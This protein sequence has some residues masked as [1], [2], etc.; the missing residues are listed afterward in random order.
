MCVIWDV[1]RLTTLCTRNATIYGNVTPAYHSQMYCSFLV[2][3]YERGGGRYQPYD[4]YERPPPRRPYDYPPPQHYND[5]YRYDRQG[6]RDPYYNQ[7]G[8]YNYPYRESPSRQ[9]PPRF[10]QPNSLHVSW[11]LSHNL[12]SR[13]AHCKTGVW[14]KNIVPIFTNSAESRTRPIRHR[15]TRTW[16]QQILRIAQQMGLSRRL[17]IFKIVIF[18]LLTLVVSILGISKKTWDSLWNERLDIKFVRFDC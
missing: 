3:R 12:L 9:S 17:P 7:G 10:D 6:G 8:N 11:F 2:S 1:L 5:Y 4:R 13:S 16:V 18:L 14:V 15:T